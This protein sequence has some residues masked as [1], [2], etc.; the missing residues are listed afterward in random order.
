MDCA[1]LIWGSGDGLCYIN[2]GLWAKR[3]SVPRTWKSRARSTFLIMDII[4]I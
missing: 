1:I 4:I 2:M 3:H